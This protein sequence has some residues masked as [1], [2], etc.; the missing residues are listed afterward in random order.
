[1][2]TYPSIP[3]SK[4]SPIGTHCTAFY[5][6][7]GSNLRWEWSKKQGFYKFGTRTRLFDATD[8][9]FGGAIPLFMDTVAKPVEARLLDAYGKGLEQ[10]IVYTEFLGDSS[11]AGN[12]VPEEE[13]YLRLFD[14]SVYKKGMIDPVRFVELFGEFDFTAAVV[15]KGTL[16]REFVTDVQKG[17][18][19]LNEGVIAKG[20]TGHGL[21]MV[22]IKT[23]SYLARLKQNLPNWQDFWE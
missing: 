11:F 5:K 2:K 3:G 21:W 9:V 13:K 8:P 14:V 23:D 12:H 17:A 20:G 1:M 18:Y 10:F 19:P 15:Y 7:D 4:Q 6:Y 22:K 16:T